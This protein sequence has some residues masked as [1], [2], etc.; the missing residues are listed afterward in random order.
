MREARFLP[1]GPRTASAGQV[2]GHLVQQ[3]GELVAF[4]AVEVAEQAGDPAAMLVEHLLRGPPALAGQVDAQGTAVVA[5]G[6]AFDGLFT[7]VF[8]SLTLLLTT[9]AFGILSLLTLSIITFT[10]LV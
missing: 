5:V 6:D 3:G 4:I 1:S 10:F 9:F 8:S 2:A 7:S